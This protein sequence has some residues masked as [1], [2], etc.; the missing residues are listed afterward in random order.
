MLLARERERA[1]LGEV[2]GVGLA[3]VNAA[4]QPLWLT[5]RA[6]TLLSDF[7]PVKGHRATSECL[8][9]ELEAS[10]LRVLQPTGI[11][12]GEGAA[13]QPWRPVWQFAG[14]DERT[15]KV[16]LVP[17]ES[18]GRWYLLLEETNAQAAARRLVCALRLTVREGEVLHWLREGKS[19][20]EISAILGNSE[21]TVGK[22]LENIFRKLNVGN[23]TAAVRMANEASTEL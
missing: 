14:P 6:E 22:H 19:N 16:R 1:R 9:D 2:F 7:F 21:C 18:A 12:V 17:G 8:P 11:V 4:A 13:L 23:R 10:L 3:E 15:L 20:W 5:P